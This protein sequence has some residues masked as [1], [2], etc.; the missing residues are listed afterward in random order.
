MLKVGILA[1]NYVKISPF[2]KKGTEVFIEA[3]TAELNSDKNIHK[4]NST[5][6]CSGDSNVQGNK[7]AFFEKAS[8]NDPAIGQKLHSL[9]ERIH[10]SKSLE[11]CNDYDLFHVNIGNGE[12][13]LPFLPFVKIPVVITLHTTLGSRYQKKLYQMY[14]HL[15]HVYYVSISQFQREAISHLNYANTIYNG[16]DTSEFIFDKT[17]S[18]YIIWAGRGVPVKG[19]EDV[20]EVIRLTKKEARVY[21][22]LDTASI[23]WFQKDVLQPRNIIKRK[24]NIK[25]DMNISRGE[26][27]KHYQKAKLFL[28]PIKWEEPFGLV[29][30]E[31]MACG[32]PVV[33]YARGS[34]PEVVKDGETGFI[35]NSSEKDIRGKW[36]IKKT[37][38]AGLIEAVEKIYAMP[39]AEYQKMRLNCRRHV[40]KHFTIERM[41]NEYIDTYKEIVADYKRKKTA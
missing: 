35:V 36:H 4:V 24:I 32:T 31:A 7:K 9:F 18:Q 10:I 6:F 14:K 41:V 22:I 1:S 23:D 37:G 20:L 21:P 16:I 8:L 25:M 34:V 2:V 26:L 11:H 33:A 12:I 19:L 5:L 15:K 27:V 40:E 3:L 39:E 38:V 13:V 30:I 29:M 17:S 28:N